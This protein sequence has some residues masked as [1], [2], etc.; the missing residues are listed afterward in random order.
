MTHRYQAGS[1][2]SVGSDLFV[3]HIERSPLEYHRSGSVRRISLIDPSAPPPPKHDIYFA[4][5]QRN[6]YTGKTGRRLKK[7]RVEI[8][9]GAGPNVVAFVDYHDYSYDGDWSSLYV[10]YMKV[11][12]DYKGQGLSRRLI[13]ELLAAYP[14][15]KRIHFGKMM[16][17]AVGKI[18]DELKASGK[19][20]IMGHRDY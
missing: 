12:S 9:P 7:P 13:A 11:R 3:E 2:S 8:T 17:P 18:H 5:T 4:E 20:D 1:G 10:D 6:I 19:Y 14:D 15:S 16:H